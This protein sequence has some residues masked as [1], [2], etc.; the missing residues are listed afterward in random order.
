MFEKPFEQIVAA[1]RRVW[2]RLS[3]HV[4]RI[5]LL[6]QLAGGSLASS[7]G[8]CAPHAQVAG[9]GAGSPSPGPA[10]PDRRHAAAAFSSASCLRVR[11]QQ[12]CSQHPQQLPPM[13]QPDSRRRHLNKPALE[14]HGPRST[15]PSSIRSTRGCVAK[16]VKCSSASSTMPGP[17][18]AGKSSASSARRSGEEGDQAPRLGRR[19]DDGPYPHKVPRSTMARW[20]RCDGDAVARA[21]GDGRGRVPRDPAL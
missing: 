10:E 7:R 15:N 13:Q 20:I 14:A 18:T 11:V 8:S 21:S 5:T 1:S 6:S 2:M 19:V 3:S 9:G 17:N 16:R 12:P 4:R